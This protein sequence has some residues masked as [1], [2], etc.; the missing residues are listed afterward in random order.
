MAGVKAS[1]LAADL[2]RPRENN[3]EVSSLGAE[4]AAN[5]LCE[6]RRKKKEKGKPPAN[7]VPTENMPW[8]LERCNE[9]LGKI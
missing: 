9:S 1:C 6:G 7:E 2:V 8:Q 3:W 5:G 4:R